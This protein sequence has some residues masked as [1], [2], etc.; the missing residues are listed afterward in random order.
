[1][2]VTDQPIA[3]LLLS[4]KLGL[5]MGDWQD[6]RVVAVTVVMVDVVVVVRAVEDVTV[7]IVLERVRVSVSTAEEVVSTVVVAVW[8]VISRGVW[9]SDN[10]GDE[11]LRELRG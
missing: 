10:R 1:V 9:E 11:R 6:W 7:V 3:T 2:L 8:G 4:S 5:T